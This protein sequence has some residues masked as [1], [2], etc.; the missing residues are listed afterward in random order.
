MSFMAASITLRFT[1]EGGTEICT[2]ADS[3][4]TVYVPGTN[5]KSVFGMVGGEIGSA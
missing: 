4:Y 3:A 2:G 5:R 1:S